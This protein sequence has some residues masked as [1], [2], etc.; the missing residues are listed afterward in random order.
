MKTK[1]TLLMAL[2][3]LF[4]L[5]AG[6]QDQPGRPGGPG[7]PGEGGRGRF[8]PSAEDIKKYDKDGN[9]ELSREEMRGM[10]DERRKEMEKKYDADGDGKLSDEERKKMEAENPRGRGGPGGPGG[11]GGRGGFPPPTADEIKTYDKNGDGKLEGEEATALRTARQK[12]RLEKY[13]ADKD[14]KL[15]D[16]ENRKMFEDYRKQRE[17]DRAKNAA[18]GKT[19]EEKKPEPAKAPETK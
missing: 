5:N 3:G 16:E 9:G 7:G 6:A 12:A 8:Q 10:M 17:E 4:T 14:G 19:T 1:L 13:D 11:P 18:A 15:S 2:A